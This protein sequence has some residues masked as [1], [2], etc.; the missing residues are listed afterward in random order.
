[1]TYR[2]GAA[3]GQEGLGGAAAGVLVRVVD[4]QDQGRAGETD[5]NEGM[6]IAD[7]VG[8]DMQE[9][10]RIDNESWLPGGAHRRE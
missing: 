2:E 6:R 10:G 1:M 4:S 8:V 5:R 7:G 9:K 3:E